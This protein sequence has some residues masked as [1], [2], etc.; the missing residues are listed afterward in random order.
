[1]NLVLKQLGLWIAGQVLTRAPALR[2][3]MGDI[4]ALVVLAIAAGFFSG[5]LLLGLFYAEYLLLT[6][7]A[8]LTQVP[9]FTIVWLSGA[10]FLLACILVLQ[11]KV[12]NV[13]YML[14]VAKR[15]QSPVS[16]YVNPV[17][18]S[19]VDGFS[20]SAPRKGKP[21]SGSAFR[22]PATPEARPVS[23]PVIVKR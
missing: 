2:N 13:V 22:S 14:D 1:M 6:M 17:V 19:F 5:A 23:K 12:K 18:D 7:A 20:G 3:F 9:A 15:I 8:G 21:K 10:C 16:Y 11:V 4:V